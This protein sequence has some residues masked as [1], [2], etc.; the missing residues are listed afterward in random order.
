[1]TQPK[2]EAL[3]Q[4][5]LDTLITDEAWLFLH[6]VRLQARGRQP[7]QDLKEK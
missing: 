4:A 6:A 3:A 5:H 7:V 2:L 1:M